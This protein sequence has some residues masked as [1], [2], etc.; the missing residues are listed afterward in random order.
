M[1]KNT[2]RDLEAWKESME[3]VV[4]LYELSQHLPASEQYGLT[5]QMRRAAVSIP[6]NIAEGQSRRSNKEF[7]HHLSIARGSLAELETQ[8]ILCVRL[9]FIQRDQAKQVWRHAELSGK[10]I[11]G[12]MRSLERKVPS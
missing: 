1:T 6:S 2:Y 12:L 7:L 10:L 11:N 8:L 9:N 4:S 3:L 5:S